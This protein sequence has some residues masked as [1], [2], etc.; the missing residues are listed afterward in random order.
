MKII[1]EENIE[2]QSLQGRQNLIWS[3]PFLPEPFF[4]CTY[5][6]YI[7]NSWKLPIIHTG[8]GTTWEIQTINFAAPA[9]FAIIFL[10]CY[11]G[12][13]VT[14]KVVQLED[15][16]KDDIVGICCHDNIIGLAYEHCIR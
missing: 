1:Y 16:S 11:K 9:L 15:F 8:S 12:T 5:E 4:T 6:I 14:V 7:V 2:P 3:R 13:E 10:F